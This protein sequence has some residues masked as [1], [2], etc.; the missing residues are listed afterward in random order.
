MR[1]KIFIKAQ[2]AFIKTQQNYPQM[3]D[4]SQSNVSEVAE[5]HLRNMFHGSTISELQDFISN[6]PSSSLVEQAMFEYGQCLH[7]MKLFSEAIILYRKIITNNPLSEYS[8]KA[9]EYIE[10]YDSIQ[11]EE[12]NLSFLI[13]NDSSSNIIADKIYYIGKMYYDFLRKYPIPQEV[14]IDLSPAFYLF[15]ELIEKYPNSQWVDNALYYI[16][17][18]KAIDSQDGGVEDF[19]AYYAKRFQELQKKYPDSEHACKLQ[20]LIGEYLSRFIYTVQYD[21]ILNLF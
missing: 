8:A 21:S 9:Q 2:E 6:N 11:N 20:Y 15:Q 19:L 18:K 3:I 17:I 16:L 7:R 14:G 1:Q 5:F 10:K 4:I 12:A 13:Q